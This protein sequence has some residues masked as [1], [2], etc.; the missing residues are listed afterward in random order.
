MALQF[1]F[2]AETYIHSAKKKFPVKKPVVHHTVNPISRPVVGDWSAKYTEGRDL[3]VADHKYV[4]QYENEENFGRISASEPNRTQVTFSEGDVESF[5]EAFTVLLNYRTQMEKSC[6]STSNELFKSYLDRYATAVSAFH[7]DGLPMGSDISTNNDSIVLI[8][9]RTTLKDAT[10][11]VA[12]YLNSKQSRFKEFIPKYVEADKLLKESFNTIAKVLK[13]EVSDSDRD[14]P[15]SIRE[16]NLETVSKLPR[17]SIFQA[18]E[19]LTE[20]K[21]GVCI[22]SAENLTEVATPKTTPAE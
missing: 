2:G 14:R 18:A 19:S 4:L 20:G 17:F 10:I 3:L 15:Y 22:V 21:E 6:R 8:V 7:R 16:N 9:N 1:T 12:R 11:L 5:K 13:V